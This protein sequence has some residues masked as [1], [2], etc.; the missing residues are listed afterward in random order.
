MF[1]R[2]KTERKFIQLTSVKCQ[3]VKH[4]LIKTQFSKTC[5]I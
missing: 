5:L 3:I 4:V 2:V 1:S